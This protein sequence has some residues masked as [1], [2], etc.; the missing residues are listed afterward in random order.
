MTE[1]LRLPLVP[2][3]NATRAIVDAAL[4]HAGLLEG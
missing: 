2:V 1:D 3:S 4:R